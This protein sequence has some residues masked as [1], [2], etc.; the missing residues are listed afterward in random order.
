[1]CNII[2]ITRIFLM[3]YNYYWKKIY[4]PLLIFMKCAIISNDSYVAFS[5]TCISVL[6]YH[7]MILFEN[8]E[9]IKISQISLYVPSFA[10]NVYSVPL[11]AVYFIY[12]LYLIIN[13]IIQCIK[14]SLSFWIYFNIYVDFTFCSEDL[15]KVNALHVYS[16][17]R[18]AN[19]F[20]K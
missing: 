6:H 16:I 9:T 5:N 4:R 2:T 17:I 12:R 18:F 3:H 15:P 1:M 19:T 13:I 11:F 14:M 8:R 10:V 20:L 7:N